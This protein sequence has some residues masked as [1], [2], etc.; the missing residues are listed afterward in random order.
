MSEP[1][2]GFLFFP[3]FAPESSTS[4]WATGASTGERL[5]AQRPELYRVVV[6]LLGQGHSIRSIKALTGVHHRTIEAVRIAEGQTIDTLRKELGA[7]A[8][9]V[10]SLAVERIEEQVATGTAKLGELA[11]AVGVLVDKGQVLT[12]GVT[13]RVERIQASEVSKEVETFIE[14]LPVAT[15][16][17]GGKAAQKVLDAGPDQAALVEPG[18]PVRDSESLVTSCDAE[19]ATSDAATTLA[20]STGSVPVTDDS[21]GGGGGVSDAGGGCCSDRSGDSENL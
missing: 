3:G 6:G 9:H 15:G 20:I 10:A 4:P 18:D 5:K 11:V 2:P 19:V 16:F 21:D 12:G 8:L 7:R 17:D 1:G 14:S 13:G